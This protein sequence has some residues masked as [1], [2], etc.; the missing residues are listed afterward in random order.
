[1]DEGSFIAEAI[2][3]KLNGDEDDADERAGS[4]D[5]RAPPNDW[6]DVPPSAT[7]ET[8]QAPARGLSD[9]LVIFGR[10]ALV[11]GAAVVGY[12]TFVSLLESAPIVAAG[13]VLVLVGFCAVRIGRRF[14]E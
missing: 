12:D 7:G 9:I 5:A 2:R 14:R 3:E 13:F 11:L 8:E 1:M 6:G 10:V 4:D